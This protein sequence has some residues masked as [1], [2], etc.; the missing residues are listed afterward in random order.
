[1]LGK[2]ISSVG[3]GSID[4]LVKG[5]L[6]KLLRKYAVNKGGK[7]GEVAIMLQLRKEGDEIIFSGWSV[8]NECDFAHKEWIEEDEVIKLLKD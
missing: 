3:G 4:K 1:M 8:E 7:D 2:L 6:V 5:F